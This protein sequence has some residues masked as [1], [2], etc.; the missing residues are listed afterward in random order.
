MGRLEKGPRAEGALVYSWSGGG[1]LR[2]AAVVAEA[3]CWD[4]LKT[5][6]INNICQLSACRM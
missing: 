2:A 6:L 5:E 4:I 3:G 1:S